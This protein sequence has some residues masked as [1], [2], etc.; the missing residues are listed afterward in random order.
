MKAYGPAFEQVRQILAS[1]TQAEPL[2][3]AKDIWHQLTC[4]PVPPL[5]TVQRYMHEI[6]TAQPVVERQVVVRRQTSPHH[7]G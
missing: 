3:E 7:V 2:L 1:R 5:R 6:R 4:W